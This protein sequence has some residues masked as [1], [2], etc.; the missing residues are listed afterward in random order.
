MMLGPLRQMAQHYGGAAE[1]TLFVLFTVLF[2]LRAIWWFVL[3]I[4][5]LFGSPQCRT[6][7]RWLLTPF[8]RRR[9]SGELDEGRGEAQDDGPPEY[10]AHQRRQSRQPRWRCPGSGRF[11]VRCPRP[12]DHASDG[13][14]EPDEDSRR[15][16]R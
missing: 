1:M 12:G 5:A 15:G 2:T 9:E 3:R 10:S 7:A 4:T 8:W 6:N 14:D 13:E 16:G 11:G